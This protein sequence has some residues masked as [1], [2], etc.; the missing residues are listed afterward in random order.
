MTPPVTTPPVAAPPAAATPAAASTDTTAATSAATPPV[1]RSFAPPVFAGVLTSLPEALRAQAADA[2][3][4]AALAEHA[5]V[6]SFARFVQELMYLAAPPELIVAAL[7]AAREEVEHAQA[8][9]AIASA[10][11][12][13]PLGPGPLPVVE[14]REVDFA[15]LA[16]T[17]FDEACL[18]ET[19]GAMAA[20]EAAERCVDPEVRAVLER[21]AVEEARHAD[22]AWK[23]IGWAL[24]SGGA[25]VRVALEEARDTLPLSAPARVED[26]DE[27]TEALLR[28]GVITDAWLARRRDHVAATVV[29]PALQALLEATPGPV[30]APPAPPAA[31]SGKPEGNR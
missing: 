20:Q 2:W 1:A 16:R 4:D 30:A 24:A 8:S 17:T 12:G 29:R 14:P 18:E 31:H 26:D 19:L 10:L 15:E 6:A 11:A 23:A 22:L 9:F 13:E 7:D 27:A 25:A 21:I 3:V 28:A 5:S